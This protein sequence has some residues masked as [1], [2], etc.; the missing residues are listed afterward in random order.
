MEGEGERDVALKRAQAALDWNHVAVSL[1]AHPSG[2]TGQG[3]SVEG[4][5]AAHERRRTTMSTSG[6]HPF[7]Q[8]SLCVV[9]IYST[10][11]IWALV[12]TMIV[13]VRHTLLNDSA[14]VPGT[15]CVEDSLTWN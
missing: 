10:F 2:R 9:G 11:L 13:D 7:A 5:H 15:T 6:L 1:S 3:Q 14:A 12:R 8:L 4:S